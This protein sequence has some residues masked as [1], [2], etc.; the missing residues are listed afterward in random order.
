VEKLAELGIKHTL[1]L[2]DRILTAEDRVALAVEIGV[3][4]EVI[5]P[6]AKLTELSYIHWVNH[7]FAYLFLEAGF[8]TSAQVA[9]AEP[10]Q[11]TADVKALNIKQEIYKWQIGCMK[12]CCV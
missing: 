9:R 3:E 4:K 10:E 8:E 1:Q 12:W 5:L 11:L 7:T 2:Y 6:L